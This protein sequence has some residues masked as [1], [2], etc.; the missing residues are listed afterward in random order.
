E[1]KDVPD[2]H[3]NYIVAGTLGG[4]FL[5]TMVSNASSRNSGPEVLATGVGA[6]LGFVLVAATITSSPQK[7][8]RDADDLGT[9]EFNFDPGGAALALTGAR[10]NSDRAPGMRISVPIASFSLKL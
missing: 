8:L 7:G 9:M 5:G 1:Q 10:L 3:G 2:G 6:V 4:A